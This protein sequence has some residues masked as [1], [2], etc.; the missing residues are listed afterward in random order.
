M[1]S[2]QFD[3][4]KALKMYIAYLENVSLSLKDIKKDI[5]D[6]IMMQINNHIYE[7]FTND[8][9]TEIERLQK[10]LSELGDPGAY[11][12][13][14]T[15]LNKLD[16]ALNKNRLFGITKHL[17]RLAKKSILF[18]SFF[19]IY[20]VIFSTSILL[21]VKL[22]FP[23]KT[24]LFHNG[25]RFVSFGFTSKTEGLTEVLHFWFYPLV[26]FLIAILY[27]TLRFILLKIA[28]KSFRIM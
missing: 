18:T 27:F 7:S 22:F 24:G 26:I 15:E 12:H 17:Y 14:F 6:D 25:H 2:I 11:L 28:N 5:R 19:V 8:T 20:I 3:D 9:G 16:H 13:E 10:T 4:S 21:F 1:K 23:D